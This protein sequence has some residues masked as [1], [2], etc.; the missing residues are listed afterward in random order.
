MDEV[1]VSLLWRKTKNCWYMQYRHPETGLKV[2]KSTGKT[3]RRDAERV[4]SKWEEKVRSGKD[5]RAGRVEWATFRTRYEDE[6]VPGLAESTAKKI[7]TV[8]DAVERVIKPQR[9]G[10]VTTD[11]MGRLVKDLREN[12]RTESTIKGYL[13]HLCAALGW[14]VTVG[15]LLTVPMA[16]KIQRAKK[17]RMMKGRPITEEELDRMIEKL[18]AALIEPMD[19]ERKRKSPKRWTAEARAAY[20][21]RRAAEAAA[22]APSWVHLMRGLWWSGLRLA[23]S[24]ELHWTDETKLCIVDI[25]TRDPMMQIPADLEKGNKDRL[26]PIAP[27][28]ARFLKAVPEDQRVGYVFNP[29]ALR[30]DK[31]DKRLG[32]Q[33]VG[34]IISLTGKLAKVKVATHTKTGKEKNAS[35]HDLRRSFGLRWAQRVMPQVLMELMRHESIETTMLYYV[36]RNAKA[37]SSILRDAERRAVGDLLGDPAQ[38]T[39]TADQRKPR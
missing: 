23:E 33:Q 5:A 7:G 4:A 22:V 29:G 10:N 20:E 39:E 25:N 14:A 21:L 30:A 34:R 9:I 13:A 38:E 27:E 17:T 8:L 2:Q 16:P 28:F 35:A 18:P 19:N 32:E 24:L 31:K 12:D 36:G 6:V 3:N 11:A 1:S 26:L 37:T 15:M